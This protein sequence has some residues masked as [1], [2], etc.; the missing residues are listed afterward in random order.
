MRESCFLKTPLP[1]AALGDFCL[2]QG[3]TR[4]SSLTGKFVYKFFLKHQT[5]YCVKANLKLMK[6]WSRPLD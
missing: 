2:L 6:I 3:E 1:P 5:F 4:P